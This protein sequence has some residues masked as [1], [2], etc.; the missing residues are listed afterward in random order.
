MR[1]IKQFEEVSQE[2]EEIVVIGSEV[3][4]SALLLIGFIK[5]KNR[6]V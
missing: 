6:F 5:Y 1:H 2:T 4:V 3:I